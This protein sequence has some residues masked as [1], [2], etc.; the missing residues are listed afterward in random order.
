MLGLLSTSLFL[1]IGGVFEPRASAQG[2]NAFGPSSAVQDE[3]SAKK[4]VQVAEDGLKN[5]TPNN[6]A[7]E[8]DQSDDTLNSDGEFA[9]LPQSTNQATSA[10]R[11][12]TSDF[13]NGGNNLFGNSSE[14]GDATLVNPTNAAGSGK[15]SE[16]QPDAFGTDGG[17]DLTGETAENPI[18]ATSQSTKSPPEIIDATVSPNPEA[19]APAVGPL[20]PSANVPLPNGALG[21][22][23]TTG[24]APANAQVLLDE[25]KKEDAPPANFNTVTSGPSPQGILSPST[26]Q[27]GVSNGSAPSG[28]VA[29]SGGMPPMLKELPPP[30]EFAGAPPIPG[31]MRIMAEGEAPQEYRVQPGDTLYDICDQL[32]DEAGYWPKLWSLNPEI[33]NPHFIFP[34]MKLG[35]YPGD[36]ETPPYLQVIQEEDIIPIDKGALN[37]IALV[38]ESVT[39]SEEL[40]APAEQVIEV[41]GPDQVEVGS[42]ID[43]AVLSGGRVYNGSDIRLQVPG[44]I[45]TEDKAELGYVIGGR[46]GGLTVA[47]GQEVVI[48]PAGQL[49]TG[50]IYTVLRRHDKVTNPLSGDDIGVLYYFVGNV[51]I[52]R[53]VGSDIF[54]GRVQDNL[55]GV[56]ADDIIVDYISTY[57]TIPT[58]HSGASYTALDAVV[59]AFEYPDGELGGDGHFVFL[60]KGSGAGV[61]PGMYVRVYQKPGYLMNSS[62]DADLPEDWQGVAT[63]RIID[64][65]DAGSVGYVVDSSQEV[66]IG[67][68]TKKP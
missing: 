25:I 52:M 11:N 22:G 10:P 44:F 2:A 41:V 31:T 47:P 15:V 36:D 12:S 28:G 16:V 14:S 33:K 43:E 37:E 45:F 63:M 8:F 3:V 5:A 58:K 65:T 32:I 27:S 7:V 68:L 17:S 48:E 20:N 54:I 49:T 51:K 13:G 4:T 46:S 29:S 56:Q 6:D 23:V 55:L 38:K 19:Q 21:N 61:T 64:V 30:N 34:G 66:R 62:G 67:D 18:S 57:R 42:E 59:V 60:D 26:G 40:T 35:F 24:S 39:L 9:D 50:Q 53:P 1:L